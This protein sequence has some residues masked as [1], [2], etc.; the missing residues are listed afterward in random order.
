MKVAFTG[1]CEYLG[2]LLIAQMAGTEE[3]P[4]TVATDL[5]A[6]LPVDLRVIVKEKILSAPCILHS[7]RNWEIWKIPPNF[8]GEELLNKI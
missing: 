3:I 6:Q 8:T 1:I 7:R 4:Q 2:S 5:K